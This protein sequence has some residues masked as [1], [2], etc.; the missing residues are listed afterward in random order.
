MILKHSLAVRPGVALLM[1][2]MAATRFGHFGSTVDLPDAS[3]A[4]F[5]GAGLWLGGRYL[6]AALVAEAFMIDYLAISQ[7]AVSDFCISPAYG[8][9]LVGYVVMWLAGGYCRRLP[10]LSTA[11]SLKQLLVLAIATS[12]AFLISN[13]S[14]FWL[15]EQVS[16]KSWAH[17]ADNLATY[18]P[19]YFSVTVLYGIAITVVREMAKALWTQAGKVLRHSL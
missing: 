5:F 14:F 8:F 1:A 11:N 6:L 3:L 12:L 16:N 9:L 13:G 19:A 10:L 4:V 7:F 2:L 15:A 18:F 17:Y